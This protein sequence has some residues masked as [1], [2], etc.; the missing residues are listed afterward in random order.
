MPQ[1]YDVPHE[2]EQDLRQV[3]RGEVRFDEGSRALYSTDA[4]NYR[5]LPVGVLIPLD[6]EDIIAAIAVCR[7]HGAPVLMRGAGTSLSGQGC[8]FAVVLD[9]TKHFN[10]ILE[11][12]TVRRLARIEPGVVLDELRAALAPHGLT[13]GPD[14]SS[15]SRCTLGGMIGNNSCGVHSVMA[16]KTAENIETLDIL[17]YD[18]VRMELGATSEAE[19]QTIIQGGGRRGEIYARLKVLRDRYTEYINTGFPAIPRRVSG[20]NLDQL[21]EQNGFNLA[22][23][24]VGSEGTCAVILGATVRL[25][26]DPPARVLLVIAYP[27]I[28]LAGDQTPV[29]L[30]HLPIGLEGLDQGMIEAMRRKHLQLDDI[31]LLPRGGAWLLVEFGGATSLEAE[32]SARNL[33]TELDSLGIASAM[34]LFVDP[35]MQ[36]KVWAIRESGA[37]ATN[38][39]PGERNTYP[40]W[41]DA[42]VDPARIG[43]YLRDFR[44]LLDSYGYQAALYGH[45]GDGCV[46]ARIDFDLSNAAGI[47]HW[48]AFLMD[49]ADLVVRFGGSL[50]GEHGDGQAKGEL[51]PRMFGPELMRALV[52][53]KAIWDP[54]NRMNPGKLIHAYAVDANLRTGPEYRPLE[55]ATYFSFARDE[56]SFAKAAGRCVGFAKC[57]RAEG[58]AM[59]P[60]Y[61]ATHEEKY[62]TRGRARMLFE[63]LQG[64]VL[65]EGW[66]NEQIKEALELCLS[67]KSCKAE[68]PVQVDM[69]TYKAEFLAHYYQGR[70]RPR[71][72][73]TMGLIHLWVQVAMWAPRL[74]NLM[75]RLP[76][77][78]SVIK[79]GA[80]IA[81]SRQLP[82]FAPQS[83]RQQFECRTLSEN[84]QEVLL[85]TDT[86]TN[87]FQPEIATAAVEVLE[88]AGFRVGIP[89][90]GLCC[91]RPLFDFG[92][93]ER[94]KQ[95]LQEILD[96]LADDIA[97]GVPVIGLEP[98]CVSVFR[99]ELLNLFPQDPVAARLAQQTF[100]LNE[101][102]VQQDFQPPPLHRTA[103]VH[104]HC[105]HKAVLGMHPEMEMLQ[106]MQLDVTLLDSGCC[107][108]AGTFGMHL[109]HYD[110]SMRIGEAVL[111][112]AL[113]NLQE[114][115]LIVADGFSCREQIIH[116]TGRRP[117]HSAQVLQLALSQATFLIKE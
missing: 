8:N 17:T 80:G 26:P 78:R 66:R 103:V 36:L 54:D 71:Q 113:R 52:E 92:M 48:R 56:G 62:V 27:D 9:T 24:L 32:H 58:G 96:A 3:V 60:S 19:L 4:S 117:L 94:A 40:G 95:Q 91:G 29:V 76:G 115:V 53:F 2:L 16:G 31:V 93:L 105:H 97:R 43:D 37:A 55:P 109:R 79:W 98:A 73:Y 114:D 84:G 11:I 106:R 87:N 28:Y 111:L 18:G 10:R 41:E 63:M 77:L 102:L 74:I 12:D 20:Y 14:P 22:R 45:F 86:F 59:C 57:R 15:H 104:G 100:T 49:A 116:G 44:A 110:T 34:E 47:S 13:F 6:E 75:T 83:F 85:W 70:L 69:A 33:M 81:S 30:R 89:R 42:A 67:C 108:M 82:R 50:S 23:A 39:V 99:D 38:A 90:H 35:V 64:E 101:F 65:R 88:A 5:Q 72:A 107:G 68:C 21:L 61:R 46:H 7:R 112:P 51:L 25:I 1:P